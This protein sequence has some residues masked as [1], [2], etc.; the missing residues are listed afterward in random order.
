MGREGPCRHMSLVCVVSTCS[1]PATMGLPLLMECELSPSTLFRLQAA[2]QGVDPKLHALPRPKP[3]RFRLSGTPLRHRLGWACVLCLPGQSSSDGQELDDTLSLGQC[4]FS[5]LRS[6]PQFPG[7]P[8]RCA[9]CPFWEA[10]FWLRPFRRML[11]I[12]NL[13]KSLVRD[14]KPVCPLVGGALSGAEFTLFPSLCLLPP[15]GDGPSTAS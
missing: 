4:A 13:R 2:L 9:L 12:Q 7:A 10:D 14:W 15:A 5:P 1:V 3:L 6:Q 8:V 11:T